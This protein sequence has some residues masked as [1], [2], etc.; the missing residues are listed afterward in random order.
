MAG[1]GV[2]EGGRGSEGAVRRR[3][4]LQEFIRANELEPAAWARQAG[5]KSANAIYNFLKGRAS[6]LSA[7]TYERLA[8]AVPGATVAQLTG[9]R[10][11]GRPALSHNIRIREIAASGVLRLSPELPSDEQ[12]GASIP[13]GPMRARGAFGVRLEGE[14]MDLDWP[15]GTIFVVVPLVMHG[16]PDEH[17][18][19]LLRRMRG[20]KFETFIRELRRDPIVPERGWLW[21]RSS[22]AEHQAPM[23]CPWP[24][25]A[26]FDDGEGNR[27][28]ATAVAIGAYLRLNVSAR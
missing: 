28:E 24:L 18:I 19:V 3:R 4:A 17:S 21:P 26:P 23:P 27:V 15:P 8:S 22:H 16:A 14:D 11:A 2:P 9:E 20:R 10:V 12:E 5:F 6:S 13:E 7:D 1:V 25:E